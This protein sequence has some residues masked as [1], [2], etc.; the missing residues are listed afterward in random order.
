MSIRKGGDISQF[1]EFLSLL[2][3]ATGNLFL[4]AEYIRARVVIN[5]VRDV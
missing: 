3:L 5:E 4:S 1:I 2:L